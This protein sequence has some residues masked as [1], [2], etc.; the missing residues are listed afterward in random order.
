MTYAC[1]TGKKSLISQFLSVPFHS[2]L[3][4]L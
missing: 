4:Y 3:F 2:N 1:E